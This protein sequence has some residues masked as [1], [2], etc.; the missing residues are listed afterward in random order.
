MMP[1]TVS[2]TNQKHSSLFKKCS[3]L[4]CLFQ[5]KLSQCKGRQFCFCLNVLLCIW[6][7][8]IQCNRQAQR[9]ILSMFWFFII[10]LKLWNQ[11][12]NFCWFPSNCT[13]T[14]QRFYVVFVSFRISHCDINFIIHILTA[15]KVWWKATVVFLEHGLYEVSSKNGIYDIVKR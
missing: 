6:R 10:T 8:L 5:H 3:L 4:I 12:K 15:L 2:T 7:T 1:R 13:R 14:L 9:I 11:R